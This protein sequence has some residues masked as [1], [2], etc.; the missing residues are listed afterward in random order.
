MEGQRGAG[1]GGGNGHPR[2]GPALEHPQAW[3]SWVETVGLEVG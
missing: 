3:L 1:D 2:Q